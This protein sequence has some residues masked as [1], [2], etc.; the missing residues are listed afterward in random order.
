MNVA[1][2]EAFYNPRSTRTDRQF[3]TPKFASE[4][5]DSIA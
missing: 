3:A 5:M 4:R 2:S 1:N